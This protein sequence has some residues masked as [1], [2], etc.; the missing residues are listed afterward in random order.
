MA[1]NKP[2][3]LMLDLLYGIEHRILED[4]LGHAIPRY[5]VRNSLLCRALV[6]LQ[7]QRQML[8]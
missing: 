6:V 5:I 2:S 7:V 3:Q 8:S 1:N 4:K